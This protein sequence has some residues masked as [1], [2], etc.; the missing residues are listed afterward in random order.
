MWLKFNING[1]VSIKIDILE[2]RPKIIQIYV[3]ILSY[4]LKYSY[5][6]RINYNG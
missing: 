2:V 1:S 4:L 3:L 6:Y 5:E